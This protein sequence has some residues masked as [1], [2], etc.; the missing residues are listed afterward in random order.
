MKLPEQLQQAIESEIEIAGLKELA[1]AREEL[2]GRYRR[3]SGGKRQFMTTDLERQSYIATR[4]PATYAAVYSALQAVKERTPG[5]QIKRLL[6]LGTGPGTA[7]WAACECFPEIESITLVEKDQA[8]AAIGQRLA[9]HSA[10][11]AMQKANWQIADLENLPSLQTHDLVILSYSIGELVPA[12]MLPL[13][14]QCWQSAEQA[15]VVI[16]PGTP[17]GFERIRLIRRQLIEMGSH[18]VAPCP[19]QS[20]CPMSHSDWCHFAARVERSSFHRRLKGAVLSYEDEKFSYVA[21]T[22]ECFPLP[23]ARILR[24]PQ[25]H[26]GHV[27]L[28]LC[29]ESGVR[30]PTISKRTPDAYKQARK[31]EWGEVWEEKSQTEGKKDEGVS[32]NC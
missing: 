26:S 27:Q 14:E 30:Q 10:H 8:L 25:Q 23:A 2:T 1:E 7:M 31:A 17:A 9:R 19:H 24:H 12:S 13:I 22:K 21:G 3:L 4:L 28:T 32:L 20:A 15:L 6:D 11:P 29:T 5:L 18:L 16:E